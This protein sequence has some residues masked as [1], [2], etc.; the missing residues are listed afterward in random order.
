MV[1]KTKARLVL[2]LR[3]E[4]LSLRQ[5]EAQGVSQHSVIKVE[6]AAARK[7]L[8]WETAAGMTET[9]VYERLFPDS[10]TRESVYEQPDW[11]QLH[12]ELAKVGVTLK[13]L[14]AEYRDHCHTSGAPSM[15]YDR[16][17]KTYAHYVS[18]QGVSSRVGH[19]AGQT[20]EV[21][22][23]GPTMHL[24]DPVTGQT[25]RVYLFVGCLPFSR[26]GFVEPTLD[27]RQD[28]WL[29]CHVAMFDWFGGTTPRIVPDNLKTG[30]IKHPRE[31]EIILNDAYRELAAHYS[32]AVLPGRP[33]RPKDKA[34]V[35]NT[36]WSVAT[37]VIASLRQ[38]EFA[39]LPELRAA[40][41]EQMTR[42]NQE[43]FQKRAGSRR[44]VFEEEEFPRLR[45]LPAVPYEISRWA[46]ARR[47]GRGGHVV[48]EKNH[49][50]FPYPH[51][52]ELVD[53]RVPSRVVE[54]Y[55]GAD[56]LASHPL[57]PTG[58]TGEY[59]T[60]DSDLPDGPKY[61]GWDGERVREWAA[62]IGVHTST[63]VARI[64]ASVPVEEQGLN[65]ALAVLRLTRRYSSSRV[66]RACEI[67]LQSRVRSPRYARLRPIL[68]TRQDETRRHPSFTETATATVESAA[69]AGYVRGA[70]YYGGDAS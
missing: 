69:P 66:E 56:R 65:P 44:S 19:K 15:G 54:I 45:P 8:T 27:M 14:H 57:A 22:W 3:G 28:T 1:R 59:V 5:I 29:T 40:I 48:W 21:D 18:A 26:Y 24:T 43:P 68:E 47:A 70:A 17:C 25:T 13:L 30:V 58:V 6:R 53:L 55:L 2:Q 10:G 51:V 41:Y 9:E 63:V 38:Q 61:Q 60:H 49:Y 36:V 11:P 16:F 52:G 37:W 42:F 12:R 39:T 23:S 34:S 67:V 20:V 62:R 46:Y 4:G 35:E 50:S 33:R 7:Q 64:F 32:A 31:G